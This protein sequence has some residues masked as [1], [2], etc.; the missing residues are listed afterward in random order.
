MRLYL[1]ERIEAIEQTEE[2]QTARAIAEKR[3]QA[4]AKALK[5]KSS[6]AAASAAGSI[7]PPVLPAAP[8]D[9]LVALAVQWHNSLETWR[10]GSGRWISA[11]DPDAVLFP[12]VRR[13]IFDRLTEYRTRAR[14][15]GL[16]LDIAIA[17]VDQKINEEIGRV[18]PWLDLAGE[19][20][21]NVQLAQRLESDERRAT[22]QG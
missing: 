6:N 20:H 7:P 16:P 18:F 17:A 22:A 13:F 12:I 2:F 4:A 1:R 5:T 15:V 14:P 19:N 9:E 21:G 10:N 11:E 8:R 3:Q